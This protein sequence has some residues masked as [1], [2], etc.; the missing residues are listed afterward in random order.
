MSKQKRW[1]VFLIISLTLI[2]GYLFYKNF[3][4]K[5]ETQKVEEIEKLEISAGVVPHH[6]LAEEII[7]NFFEELNSSSSLQTVILFSPDH[8]NQTALTGGHFIT[9]SSQIISTLTQNSLVKVN[10]F[11]VS[12]DQGVM[13]LMPFFQKYLPEIEVIPIL[14]SPLATKEETRELVEELNK[15]IP[16]NT[17]FLASVDFSH[18]LPLPL[19]LLHDV[20]SIRTLLN[21]EEA[22]FQKLDVDSWQALYAIRYFAKLK[23]MEE[24]RTIGHK[25]N[26]DFIES[27]PENSLLN[28]EGG[29]SYYSVI[30]KEGAKQE[31][32]QN[33]ILFVGD[34]MMA[35][36]VAQLLDKYGL[37]YP[38]KKIKNIFRG[39]DV[40]YG[41]L[42]GPIMANAAP[43][44]SHSLSF[45]YP[46]EIGELLKNLGFTVLNIANNH[47]KDKGNQG[48]EE[49]RKYLQENNIYSLGDYQ[50]CDSK[51][52]FQKDN[53]ILIGAN[54]TYGNYNCVEKILENVEKLK[55]ENSNL[56]II[57]TPHWGEEYTF[58]PTKFQEN[59]SHRFI[60]KGV[61]AIIGHHP[62]V[63][64][65]VE[66][67][68]GKPIFYS[69]GN[70]VFDMYFS[71]EVQQELAVG[72]EINP[73]EANFY[74]I[75]IKSEKSQ[76]SLMNSEETSNFL[77]WLSKISSP[78]L[79][80]SIQNGMIKISL[81]K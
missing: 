77:T 58:F 73:K 40:V 68:K 11:S 36:G 4:P 26:Y 64:Q 71:K 14:I 15:I 76:L 46:P 66:E 33:S 6:L 27:L 30:F 63:V 47:I 32:S 52:Y 35:R 2:L 28:K 51:Y 49:T 34:I 75:P 54:L 16:E 48:L 62:H 55:K 61:D 13:N 43:V 3:V 57:V 81:T 22:E 44:S 65:L 56:Y 5:K 17:I 29:V 79:K 7:N 20:K 60:D 39:I 45:A 78:S 38:Y 50:S 18:Y 24:P 25:T 80:D 41:N 59:T 70:F 12:Q 42:E 23:Q 10:E 67:Y 69:L 1:L 9:I 19:L 37:D 53:L 21:F 31:I 8:Y 74:L 72:L